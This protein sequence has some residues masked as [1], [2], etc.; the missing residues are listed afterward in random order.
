[1]F[2]RTMKSLA[3]AFALALGAVAVSC[4]GGLLDSLT[5][6]LFGS[7]LGVSDGQ[8]VVLVAVAAACGGSP[9][10]PATAST[11]G[12]VQPPNVPVQG[13]AYVLGGSIPQGEY[14]GVQP[15]FPAFTPDP[16]AAAAVR[17]IRDHG[18]TG[19][20]YGFSFPP[21]VHLYAGPD[22]SHVV[23]TVPEGQR[24]L[25]S[26]PVLWTSA[27]G[28]RWLAF[29]IAC[30]GSNL[31]WVSVDQVRS[32]SADAGNLLVRVIPQLLAAP[33]YSPAS[34]PRASALPL[35]IGSDRQFAWKDPAVHLVIARGQLLGF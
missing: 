23:G 32:V 9:A 31:Y 3:L 11:T 4:Y 29:F 33:P 25:T 34:N 8:V 27:G 17:S 16:A 20:V 12:I 6:L 21:G 24:V 2:Q 18:G 22:R 30:G 35:T 26:E 14:P 5:G 1:M 10:R 7:F 13:C 15:P 28:A 19:L